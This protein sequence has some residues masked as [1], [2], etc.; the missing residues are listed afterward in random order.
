MTGVG[1]AKAGDEVV[2]LAVVVA[3]LANLYF[4]YRVVP[5][6]RPGSWRRIWLLASL[7]TFMFLV[8]E[9]VTLLEVRMEALDHLHQIPLFGA[10]LAAATGFFLV[11]TDGYRAA[12]RSRVLALTD[13]L[14]G[15][16]NRRAF[17]ERLKIAFERSE[18]FT[19]FYVDLDGFKL[20]NDRLGHAAGDEGLRAVGTVL[21]GCVRAGDIAARLGGDEFGLFLAGE[22]PDATTI[23]G[24]RVR[25][26]VA[27]ASLPGGAKVRAS[28]GVATG[29]EG[30]TPEQVLVVADGRMYEA[31]RRAKEA[32][33]REAATTAARS[34][35]VA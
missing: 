6:K 9:A 16:P 3:L 1:Q 22:D 29:R 31:K 27:E 7:A 34:S 33:T 28:F 25:A 14:T 17:E 19:V 8:A 11:Y 18:R 32:A 30:G 23:V 4:L 26:R 20:I 21:S 24:E 12:E 35:G 2:A 10:L 13:P 15:L 5:W